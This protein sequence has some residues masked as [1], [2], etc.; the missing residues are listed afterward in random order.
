MLSSPHIVF[1]DILVSTKKFIGVILVCMKVLFIRNLYYIPLFY[2]YTDTLCFTNILI[3]PK[4]K[5]LYRS[6][7][8][9]RSCFELLKK[10]IRVYDVNSYVH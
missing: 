10:S 7:K 4:G 6:L 1:T 9:I 8:F 3:I 5:G 2:L